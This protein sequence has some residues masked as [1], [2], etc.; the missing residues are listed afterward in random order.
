MYDDGDN[1]GVVVLV[2]AVILLC[3]SP[4]STRMIMMKAAELNFL[5]GEY[6]FFNIDLFSRYWLSTSSYST[7]RM[8]LVRSRKQPNWFCGTFAD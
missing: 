1:D 6:A 4:E 2:F 5:N 8:L 7:V 3:A